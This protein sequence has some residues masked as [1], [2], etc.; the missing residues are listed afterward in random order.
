LG[1]S[2]ASLLKVEIACWVSPRANWARP[3]RSSNSTLS[4]KAARAVWAAAIAGLG[5]LLASR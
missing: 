3:R 1:C 5:W 2:W 4:G